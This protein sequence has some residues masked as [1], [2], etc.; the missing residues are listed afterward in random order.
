MTKP[1]FTIDRMLTD[2][3]LLGSQLGDI[4]TW[5]TW[6]AILKAAFALPLA[7]T[8]LEVF[9]A[10]T[11]NRPLPKARVRELWVAAGRRGGKSRMAA[12]LAVYFALFEPHRLSVGENAMVLVLAA[13]LDQSKVVFDYVRAFLQ[14]SEV[15]KREIELSTRSEDPT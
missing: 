11:G 14:N 3:R 6:L 15:L 13:S 12:A 1:T 10:V 2:P 8:E 7:P 9:Q 5:A 4:S